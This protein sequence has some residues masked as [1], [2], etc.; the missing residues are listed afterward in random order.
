MF[1]S[2]HLMLLSSFLCHSA[3]NWLPHNK[4]IHPFKLWKESYSLLVVKPLVGTYICTLECSVNY[5][6]KWASEIKLFQRLLNLGIFSWLWTCSLISSVPHKFLSQELVFVCKWTPIVPF[7]NHLLG[8]I[9]FSKCACS[10]LF[11]G[12][13]H[14]ISLAVNGNS[15]TALPE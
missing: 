15:P 13:A 10:L 2:S 4:E 7:P 5:N 3:Q 9:K 8:K 1:L 6:N 11:P 14:S 12:L